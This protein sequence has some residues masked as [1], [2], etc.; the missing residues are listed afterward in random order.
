MI[1]VRSRFRR[2]IS[3]DSDWLNM[4][5]IALIGYQ[6]LARLRTAITQHSGVCV[7]F[8]RLRRTLNPEALGNLPVAIQ[9]DRNLIFGELSDTVLI[10]KPPAGFSGSSA[11]HVKL[12]F[13]L[14]PHC[15]DG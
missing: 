1:V 12:A 6:R 4:M 13:H 2:Y 5:S 7:Q 14:M 10:K 15:M 3:I 11:N 8:N 9:C